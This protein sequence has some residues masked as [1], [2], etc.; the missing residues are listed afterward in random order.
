MLPAPS[1]AVNGFRRRAAAGAF[2]GGALQGLGWLALGWAGTL[3]AVRF[4]GGHLAPA[5][6]WGLLALPVVA[7]G[8]FRARA[9]R[10]SPEAAA[11][12]LDRRLG[13]GGLLLSAAEGAELE[14]QWAARLQLGLEP[15]HSVLPR[16]RWRHLLPVPMLSV[17]LATA[18]ALLPPPPPPPAGT[19]PLAGLRAEVE[20]LTAQAQATFERGQ[21][22]EDVRQELEQKLAELQHRLDAGEVPEWRELDQLDQ[23]LAREALLQATREPGGSPGDAGTPAAGDRTAAPT[24]GQLAAA[25]AALA[26]TGLLDRL[27]GELRA[28]LQQATRP[29]GTIDPAALP[30]DPA[31]LQRLAE[32]M[33]G[34]L[35]KAGD[36]ELGA[37]L[38]PG[39]LA[40][41]KKVLEQ[42]GHGQGPGQVPGQGGGDGQGDGDG[43]G[44]QGGRG[45]VSRGP[46]H[47]ALRMTEDAQGGAEAALPLPPGRALPGDWVP[48]GSSKSEPQVAPEANT[49]PGGAGEQGA[50]GAS[51][52]LDLAPRHREVVRRFFG[53]GGA[54]GKDKR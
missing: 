18:V 46:G 10:L 15:L 40:D 50:G 22:P 24:P 28:A 45:G 8:A 33:A 42:F 36:G 53:E 52:Q 11:A 5:V 16:A 51:W 14:P 29:D 49:A 17:A 35:G 4:G 54:A 20:R 39:Q 12:H 48:L 47:S 30:Q 44:D 37:G 25:A 1:R 9:E 32:A 38:A 2:V 27:P 23:R 26:E 43:D 34:A 7:F 6:W 3:L 41:L 31:T 21:V 19:A 13:L